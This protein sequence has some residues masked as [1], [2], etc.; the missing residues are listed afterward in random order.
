MNVVVVLK[1][2]HHRCHHP[3]LYS[4]QSLS[5]IFFS[6]EWAFKI[7]PQRII[8]QLITS[9]T[10]ERKLRGDLKVIKFYWGCVTRFE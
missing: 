7:P 4:T 8:L 5:L 9:L 1:L 2:N 3:L 10:T 6:S